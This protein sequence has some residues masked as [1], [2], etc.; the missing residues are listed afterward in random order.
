[1]NIPT[2]ATTATISSTRRSWDDNFLRADCKPP[3]LILIIQSPPWLIFP[4]KW[5]KFYSSVS[6]YDKTILKAKHV[7][8]NHLRITRNE[9]SNY[10]SC[11]A[12]R[13][14]KNGPNQAGSDHFIR[15]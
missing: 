2:K 15:F 8:V 4:E 1:M 5:C 6:I 10:K 3:M 13:S 7:H 12:N 14:T 9:T 11:K